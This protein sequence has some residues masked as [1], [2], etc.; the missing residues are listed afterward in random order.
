MPIFLQW[1]P[2]LDCVCLWVA[3]TFFRGPFF[4]CKVCKRGGGDGGLGGR[5]LG[6]GVVMEILKGPPPD[7]AYL[8]GT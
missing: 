7:C 6:E 8:G 3:A 1:V 5:S 4:C 2:S